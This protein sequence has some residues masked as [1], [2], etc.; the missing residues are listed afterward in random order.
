MQQLQGKEKQGR[1]RQ[2]QQVRQQQQENNSKG[3]ETEEKQ[4]SVETSIAER[5]L[6]T[7]AGFNVTTRTSAKAVIKP[8]QGFLQQ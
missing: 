2:K 6:A 1:G 3:P 8:Q 4:A 7:T 5:T